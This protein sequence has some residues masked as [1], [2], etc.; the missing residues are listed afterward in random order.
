VPWFHLEKAPADHLKKRLTQLDALHRQTQKPQFVML[1]GEA[2]EIATFRA[3]ASQT[4]L[5]FFGNYPD[6]ADHADNSLYTKE[7]PPSSLSGR[8]IP[9]G[10]K[11]DFLIR[12]SG[13]GYAGIE[14]KNVREW[15]YP[16]KKF[17]TCCSS[18]APSISCRY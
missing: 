14:V 9:S 12:Q 4:D 11:V 18:A 17:A 2:L 8:R 1:L 15:F 10:K 13:A 16:V 7:E 6:L 5:D 3:L